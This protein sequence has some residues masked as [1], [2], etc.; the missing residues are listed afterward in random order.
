MAALF[1]FL[2]I[3]ITI[4]GCV[5]LYLNYSAYSIN[6]YHHITDQLVSNPS[7][8][9]NIFYGYTSFCRQEVNQTSILSKSNGNN[10]L[11]NRERVANQDYQVVNSEDFN[12]NN[13]NF[14]QFDDHTY[15]VFTD[16][17]C[18]PWSNRM[19][20][21]QVTIFTTIEQIVLY[22]ITIGILNF[23]ALLFPFFL[24]CKNLFIFLKFINQK[25]EL[26]N[27]RRQ[28]KENIKSLEEKV[29]STKDKRNQNQSE[30]SVEQLR[31]D[32][33][34]RK[35]NENIINN[36]SSYN[37]RKSHCSANKSY[38]R[39]DSTSNECSNTEENT[40]S[41]RYSSVDDRKIDFESAKQKIANKNT[42]T[43]ELQF[44]LAHHKES[45]QILL[46][47]IQKLKFCVETENDKITQK[48]QLN[49]NQNLW[50]LFFVILILAVTQTLGLI[51][52]NLPTFV[53]NEKSLLSKLSSPFQMYNLYCPGFNRTSICPLFYINVFNFVNVCLVTIGIIGLT[54][55]CCRYKFEE[56]RERDY[57]HDLGKAFVEHNQQFNYQQPQKIIEP[58]QPATIHDRSNQRV[59]R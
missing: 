46:E 59:E 50:F 56:E 58:Y 12:F 30:K 38:H 26:K 41:S 7:V 16:G 5:N 43:D 49:R 33:N 15:P 6:I 53:N 3:I 1:T 42:D 34:G 24:L 22:Q 20:P 27:L 44:L 39:Y 14:F 19:T 52:I 10:V 29:R 47:K 25:Q 54:G 32:N 2:L 11:T 55:S 48:R 18:Q 9:F 37:Q 17:Q 13:F 57:D 36:F 31:I 4:L 28:R 40:A 45:D 23:T 35:V 8:K 21:E 51:I